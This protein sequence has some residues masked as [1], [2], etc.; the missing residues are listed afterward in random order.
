MNDAAV[1]IP[2][3]AMTCLAKDFEPSIVAGAGVRPEA[4]DPGRAQRVGRPGHQR[5]LRADDHQVRAELAGQAEDLVRDGGDVRVGFGDGRDAGIARRG[6]HAVRLAAQRA[7]DGVLAPARPD[8]KN[9]HA[10]SL[11]A[12]YDSSGLSCRVWS[13]RG[14]TPTAAIGA[15][16]ISSTAL[17]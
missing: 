10:V 12:D 7:D 6:V 8:D 11:A 1:G 2:A 9:A 5:R 4:V 16:I 3:S 13:R 15:P 17:M 14:P